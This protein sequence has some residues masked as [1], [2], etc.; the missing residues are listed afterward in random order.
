MLPATAA[1]AAAFLL[2]MLLLLFLML[3][4]LLHGV[5]VWVQLPLLWLLRLLLHTPAV[6]AQSTPAAVR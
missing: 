3:Y 1:A 6:G 4:L 5:L 2:L